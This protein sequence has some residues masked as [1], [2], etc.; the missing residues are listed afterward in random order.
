MTG[1]SKRTDLNCYFVLISIK[2]FYKLHVCYP[3][4]GVTSSVDLFNCITTN[5]F[6]KFHIFTLS[7]FKGITFSLYILTT[8]ILYDICIYL[9]DQLLYNCVLNILNKLF[10]LS[11]S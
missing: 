10:D 1:M 2:Y 6:L 4:N 11:F 9:S 7:K 8:K 3:S 5:T